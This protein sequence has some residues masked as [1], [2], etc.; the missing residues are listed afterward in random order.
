MYCLTYGPK[1]GKPLTREKN[2][3]GQTRSRNSI[4]LDGMRGIYFID[5]E[6]EEY[7]KTIK[8]AMRKLGSAYGR[9]NAVQKR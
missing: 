2:K 7:K 5:P 1:L 3:N 9:G 6:D 4:M 8:N